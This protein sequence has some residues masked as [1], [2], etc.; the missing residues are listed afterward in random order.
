MSQDKRFYK[1]SKSTRNIK[2]IDHMCMFVRLN[3]M[4][5]E[6]EKKLN[7]KIKTLRQQIKTRSSWF[8]NETKQTK[9]FIKE[10]HLL[11]S[12]YYSQLIMY[13]ILA[14]KPF[15]K[16][17]ENIFA[18]FLALNRRKKTSLYISIVYWTC[19]TNK[20]EKQSPQL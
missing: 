19:S 12:F 3:T 18:A 10:R 17:A 2:I 1:Y 8:V 14:I 9:K 20:R 13:S 15:I 7:K 5:I 11:M 6:F 16:V 4:N